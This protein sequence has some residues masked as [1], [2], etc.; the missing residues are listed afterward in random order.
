MSL[1]TFKD[2]QVLING[3]FAFEMQ[4]SYGVDLE[5]LQDW[6]N[7]LPSETLRDLILSEFRI[8]IANMRLKT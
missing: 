4:S 7:D 2:K 5:S 6:F 8:H 3:K 1:L